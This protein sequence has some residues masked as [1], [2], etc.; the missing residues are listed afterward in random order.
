MNDLAL[1]EGN[2]LAAIEKASGYLSKSSLVPM[3][4][5]NKQ[6]E[7]FSALVMGHSLGLDPMQSLLEINVIQGR[8]AI[9]TKLMIALC[10]RAYPNCKFDWQRD[11]ENSSVTLGLQLDKDSKPFITTWDIPRASKMNLMGRDQYKKQ[12]ITMLSWR[13]ASEAIRFVAPDAVLG[14]Y[15]IDEAQDLPDEVEDDDIERAWQRDKSE[16]EL[17]PGHAEFI[18]PTRKYA[19]KKLKDIS[20]E[21]HE[22]R[23]DYIEK[24]TKGAKYVFNQVDYDEMNWI[25]SYRITRRI[26]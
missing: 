17:T 11:L 13:C 12:L 21:E 19:N 25:Q 24:K 18:V 23:F 5:R 22:A 8:P 26:A 3:V 10:K 15:S 9:S 14:M 2:K 1:F 4:Y 6:A 7:T 20:V 16:D